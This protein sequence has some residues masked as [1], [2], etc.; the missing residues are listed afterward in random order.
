MKNIYMFFFG[1]DRNKNKFE[2]SIER[3]NINDPINWEMIN[4]IGNQNIF[5]KQSFAC[6]P[7]FLD[8]QKGVIITG[9]IN[10]LRNE[11][12]EI[13]FINIERN[14][15]EVFS[16]LQK[17]SSF[18]NSYF[19][20]FDKYSCENEVINFSNEFNVIKFNLDKKEFI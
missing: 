10:S 6:I 8:K 20:S 3:I 2:T 16:F 18:T 1:F 14:K 9:G 15:G 7:Y 11:T 4:L 13:V 17:N 19:I 12:K 5:K